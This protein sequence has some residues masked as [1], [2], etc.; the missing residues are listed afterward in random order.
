MARV[1]YHC[2][3]D[4]KCEQLV[5]MDEAGED[6]IEV[7]LAFAFDD[8]DVRF[9]QDT[10]CLVR[11]AGPVFYGGVTRWAVRDSTLVLELNAECANTLE[12]PLRTEIYLDD[13]LEL[14]DRHLERLLGLPPVPPS[15][16]GE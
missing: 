1:G 9:G 10:Y 16:V 8:Q 13:G 3:D 7:Q 6:W 15:S 14:L 2:D 5:I 11:A 4:V 12:L